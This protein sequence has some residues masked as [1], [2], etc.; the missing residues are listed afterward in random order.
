[1]GPD[2]PFLRPVLC[3]ALLLVLAVLT[4]R[5]A[6]MYTD[7]ETLWR[8]TLARNPNS[9][10]ANNNIGV[11][12]VKKGQLEEAIA[13][14]QKA[15]QSHPDDPKTYDNLDIGSPRLMAIMPITR[16]DGTG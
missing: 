1:M 15:L 8:A 11:I 13:H 5:Q 3:G 7:N 4:W 6:G 12:L 10:L 9:F 2:K 16:R 14:F